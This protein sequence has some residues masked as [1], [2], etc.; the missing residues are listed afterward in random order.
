[1]FITR[2]SLWIHSGVVGMRMRVLEVLQ[3]FFLHQDPAVVSAAVEVKMQL[4]WVSS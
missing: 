4:V 2:F 1:M 3:F